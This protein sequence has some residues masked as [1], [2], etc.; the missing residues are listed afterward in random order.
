MPSQLNSYVQR[1]TLLLSGIRRL[2]MMPSQKNRS[3]QLR[4]LLIHVNLT[5]YFLFSP[6]PNSEIE[7][8]P[9]ACTA[10]AKALRRYHQVQAGCCHHGEGSES[11]PS[12]CHPTRSTARARKKPSG[13]LVSRREPS[14]R[15]LQ[16]GERPSSEARAGWL[17]EN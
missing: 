15:R 14:D 9:R 5:S 12:L 10:G 4:G 11:P 2:L 17:G 16:E 3:P 6:A 7:R 8:F 1:K 13:R